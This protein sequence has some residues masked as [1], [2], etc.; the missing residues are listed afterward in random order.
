ME[1]ILIPGFESLLGKSEYTYE[2]IVKD[3][4]SAE[5]VAL[6]IMLNN[7][8]SASYTKEENQQRVRNIISYRFTKKQLELLNKLYA[9]FTVRTL[10]AYKQTVFGK[11]YL[12]A[13]I[14]KELNRNAKCA[15]QDTSPQQEYNLLMAY[16][17]VV[18]EVNSIDS[19]LLKDA[20]THSAD[21]LFVYRLLWPTQLHQYQFNENPNFPFELFKL[22]CLLK[23]TLDNFKPYLKEYL[24]G[25]GFPTVGT[26]L[27]SSY[28]VGNVTTLESDGMMKKL[29]YIMPTDGTDRRHLEAMSINALMG[30]GKRISLSDIKRCPLFHV[31]GK[32]YLIIDHDILLKKL[33]KGPLF[34]LHRNTRLRENMTFKSYYTTI[35]KEVVELLCFKSVI[36][37]LRTDTHDI[38]HFDNGADGVPDG[39]RRE[40]DS[41]FVFECK[42]ATMPDVLPENPNF[43]DL[44]TYIDNRLI[45]NDKGKPKGI[46]QLAQQIGKLLKGEFEFDQQYWRETR[47]RTVAIYP[48]LCIDEFYFT[49]PGVNHYLNEKFQELVAPLRSPNVVIYPVTVINLSLL[50]EM[51]FYGGNFAVLEGFI[52]KYWE[53]LSE[54]KH[55]ADTYPTHSGLFLKKYASFMEIYHTVLA[56][57][58]GERLEAGYAKMEAMIPINQ[59][60]LNEIL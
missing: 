34:E 52:K 11:R 1:M 28:Q 12:I 35:S 42:A 5:L 38:I 36:E 26:F 17:M 57:E 48:I 2:E 31:S 21:P 41:V 55:L 45:A 9:D 19:I 14:L 56:K 59:S 47:S 30:T 27:H 32:G 54:R 25:L 13:M 4:P 46:A 60:E 29:H 22:F 24:Q 15:F 49:L 40:G 3:F 6:V 8:L 16:L 37:S 50:F 51:I 33:Y 53:M 58:L 20:R 39:Y 7:E 18:D 44:K 43:D 10:G 23:Y